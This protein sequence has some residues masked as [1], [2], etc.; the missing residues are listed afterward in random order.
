[1]SR[2][3][4]AAT[5][6]S[7]RAALR[8][9]RR[10]ARRARRRTALVLAMIALPVLGL[11]F[12]AASYD[13]AELTRAEQ[14]DRRLG[15]ADAEL[16]WADLSPILQDAW[17]EQ[18]WPVEGDPVSRTRPVTTDE[19]REL[20]PAGTRFTRLRRWVPFEVRFDGRTVSFD[21]RAVDLTDPISRPLATLRE[22]RR[23]TR[24]DEIAVS[25]AALRR[26]DVGL[27]APVR[28]IDGTT[29]RVVGVV[30]FPDNLGEVVAL[31]PELPPGP[32]G[33]ADESWLVD[34][35][36]PVDGALV[37]RLNARGVLVSARNPLPGLSE[38]GAGPDLPDAEETGNMVLVGGLGLLEVVLL[39]GPAFAVGV[40][41]RR[42]DLALVAVAGGDAAHL[43]RIVLADGVVL[44]AGGAV[45]GLLLG[46]GAAIAGRPL[47]EQYL[48][49]QRFGAYRVFPAALAAI[50]VVAVLAG[51]LAALAPAWAAARQDV[52]AGLA[53]RRE[54][55]RPRRR[56]LVLGALLTVTGAAV[57]AFGAT[58]TT[59][60]GV[61]AGVVL[62]ELGLVFCTPTLIGVLARTGRLLP[63]AP[64]LALRDASRNR[65]SAAPAI[66]A[67]MAAVAGSV[68][69]GVYVASD[70]ARQRAAWQPGLPPGHVLLQR[71]DGRTT[72]PLP[73]AGEVA[74]R[75][76][77][78]LPGA[79]VV[80][81]AAPEC[82]RPEAPDD[83]CVATAVRPPE[84]RCPYDPID[85]GQP[86]ARTDPRC[87]R[88]FREPSDLYLPA[89][90]DDG[91]SL[92]ALT[93]APAEE[94]AAARRTLQ[95]GGVVVTD[96]RQVVDGRVRVEV[97]HGTGA[98]MA[99]GTLPGYVLRGG[100][101][102]DRLVVS[103][104]AATTLGLVAAPLGYLV[105]TAD[106]PTD[107]QRDRLTA[108]L[109][110]VAPL[111]VQ[112]SAAGPPSDQ[113]PLL[114][115]LAGAAGVITL[116]AAAVA[117]GLAA[118]EGRRDLSTLAAVGADPRVRRVLSLCQAGVIAG[119]GS[120]L[121]IL[122]GLGSAAIILVS[123]NRRYTQSWPVE[124]P[125]P[126]V[127]PGSTL[128]VLVV[129]PLV[130][131]VGAAL[132]TRSRLPVERRLD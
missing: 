41:R 76:R 78:V 39:V 68:A 108:E 129:V 52:V 72:G 77:S 47:V 56:W 114:L 125:Y 123:L 67:V 18:S 71:T 124:P 130:A 107:R 105:D 132:L 2:G 42:R 10:E 40:R 31:R 93:G 118:A 48:I 14:V 57:A 128:T 80:P 59:P 35:P 26:L 5:L 109:T 131:M 87:V 61:L 100:L 116:G 103:P 38:I 25:R 113:R 17:G 97:S 70:D 22:G 3:R 98:P 37:D 19:L 89:L 84:Q 44:G 45:V 1:M 82:A 63:L 11:S 20:L 50:A 24:P 106:P 62:G 86:S 110:A 115:L 54:P 46:I 88:P 33:P 120:V 96:P 91:A 30:E 23:P 126:L 49:Q 51:V 9:A 32:L 81:L 99:A 7:W 101:P 28:T 92:P 16:R 104:A 79:T 122:A 69:L 27:D 74:E 55:P 34:L 58:R 66:S 12:A 95:A 127:V 4:L 43:R 60:T 8:I 6:G 13:M 121:G 83:Y 85:P 119:L 75:V 90:V 21:A 102:V 64:R 112:V 53:G 94:V 65:S 117:T 29:Y 36:G 111:A 15:G 73:T